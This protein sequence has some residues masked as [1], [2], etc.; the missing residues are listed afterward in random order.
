V[1]A[2]TTQKTRT[3]TGHVFKRA[4]WEKRQKAIG[5]GK[6]REKGG[7]KLKKKKKHAASGGLK[8][9]SDPG[10]QVKLVGQRR[11]KS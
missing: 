6:G 8:I 5:V 3:T 4:E 7:A 9:K 2:T 1:H 10:P 11:Q